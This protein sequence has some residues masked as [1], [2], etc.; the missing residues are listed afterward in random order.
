ML[1]LPEVGRCQVLE[2]FF[3]HDVVFTADSDQRNTEFPREILDFLLMHL[4]FVDQIDLRLN[5]DSCDFFAALVMH[6]SAPSPHSFETLTIV[7][8]EC[9]YAS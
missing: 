4:G 2:N 8:R 9:K 1:L 5:Q 7:C 3:D 6:C